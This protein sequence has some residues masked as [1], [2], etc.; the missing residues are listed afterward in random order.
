MCIGGSP[1]FVSLL[2]FQQRYFISTHAPVWGAT[3]DEVY[4]HRGFQY[5]LHHFFDVFRC[6]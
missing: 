6:F 2:F 5:F 3:A 4:F 1:N